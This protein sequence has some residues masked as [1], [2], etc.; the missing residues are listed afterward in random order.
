M[1]Q[2]GTVDLEIL[3]YLKKKLAQ[4]FN[5]AFTQIEIIKEIHDPPKNSYD[6]SRKQYLS[7]LF[8]HQVRIYA[9]ENKYDKILGIT[10]LDLFVHELNFVF[11]QAE[12]GSQAKAAIISLHRLYPEFY[13]QHSNKDLFFMRIVK[14]ANH[15]IGHA[16]GLEHCLG[17]CIMVFSNSILD[18]DK[19]PARFC[20]KCRK[21]LS[22]LL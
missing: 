19:K 13:H 7:P 3:K 21:K 16:L 4:T 10:P 8:L 15:E 6:P 12:F 9:E 1:L 11:G 17:E 5:Q 2:F 22:N 20:E 18:T 14:E